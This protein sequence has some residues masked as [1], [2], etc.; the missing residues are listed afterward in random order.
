MSDETFRRLEP[1]VVHVDPGDPRNDQ[2]AAL[3]DEDLDKHIGSARK[4]RATADTQDRP[5]QMAAIATSLIDA[6][7]DDGEREIYPRDRLASMLAAALLRLA[8]AHDVKDGM[9]GP[10]IFA[11]G[12]DL[13]QLDEDTAYRLGL[14]IAK[15]TA[16]AERR[17]AERALREARES[18][19]N[20]EATQ[21]ATA[22]AVGGVKFPAAMEVA[23]LAAALQRV[24]NERDVLRDAVR[25]HSEESARPVPQGAR[26]L[27]ADAHSLLTQAAEND[28]LL[29]RHTVKAWNARLRLVLET[30]EYPGLT[31]KLLDDPRDN[32]I[33][34]GSEPS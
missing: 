30:G 6:T 13:T 18:A 10:G 21:D 14:F 9:F 28:A 16:A 5:A 23:L 15:E 20:A 22:A 17:G 31:T 29:D 12:I 33:G 2:M 4:M 8:V 11:T 1:M 27:L 19:A 24:E 32:R 3:T 25:A 34:G 7:D 26:V